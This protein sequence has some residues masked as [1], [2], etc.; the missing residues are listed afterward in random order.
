MVSASDAELIRE[1]QGWSSFDHNRHL[2]SLLKPVYGLKDAPRSWQQRL[3]SLLRQAHLRPCLMDSQLFVVTAHDLKEAGRSDLVEETPFESQV[4][5]GLTAHVDDL[6]LATTSKFDAFLKQHLEGHIGKLAE[7]RNKFVHVGIMHQV[8]RSGGVYMH[9]NA[10]VQQIQISPLGHLRTMA[11]D[12]LLASEDQQLYSSVLGAISWLQQ[13]RPDLASQTQA[14]QRRAH[15]PRK[16]DLVRAN[17]LVKFAKTHPCGLYYP[18]FKTSKSESRLL[19]FTDSS[20][21][22]KP[23]ESKALSI[24]GTAILLASSGVKHGEIKTPVH[25]LEF[26]STKHKRVVRSTFAAELGAMLDTADRAIGIQLLLSELLFDKR[27]QDAKSRMMEQHHGHTVPRITL[28]VDAKSVFET[29][30]CK[31]LHRPS[32]EPLTLPVQALRDDIQNG[33]IAEL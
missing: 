29:L 16:I 19:T 20:F 15:A 30:S 23:D 3:T 27:A 6:K 11:A 22:A 2:L 12:G 31:D 7:Q 33:R 4:Q 17:Q 13:T 8:D 5:A 32:E 18:A 10:Y 14:L 28:A 1:F 21:Q 26:Q 25:L 24:R 9:Q